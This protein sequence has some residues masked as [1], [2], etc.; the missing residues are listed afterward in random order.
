MRFRDN[1]HT[2]FYELN[3]FPGCNQLVVSNHAFIF[4]G[5]RGRGFGNLQH[6]ERL[7]K[8]KELGYN[9]IICT[10]KANN[11]PEKKILMKNNWKM[12]FQFINK[13]TNNDIEIWALTL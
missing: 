2:G 5:Y 12:V 13:E 3:S 9:C 10:V 6:K 1:S 7:E 4:P 11:L 8:A